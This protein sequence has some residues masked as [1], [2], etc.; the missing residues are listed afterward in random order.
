LIDT[1]QTLA[2]RYYFYLISQDFFRYNLVYFT[3]QLSKVHCIFS[4]FAVFV[5]EDYNIIS[6]RLCQQLF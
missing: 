6:L 5:S 2:V 4:C 1:R 3:I